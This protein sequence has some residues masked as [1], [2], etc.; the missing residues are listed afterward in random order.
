MS[1]TLHFNQLVHEHQPRAGWTARLRVRFRR[2]TLDQRLAVGAEPWS[3]TELSIRAEELTGP[4][5]RRRIAAT[6][7]RLI[8]EAEGSP[9]PMSSQVP[10]ARPAIRACTPRLRAIAGRLKSDH[11]VAPRGVAQ[12]AMLV[13]EGA[14][15]LYMVSTSET[16]LRH[17][18]A[19]V[20]EALG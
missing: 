6:I 17:R 14:S 8:A 4:Q 5:T 15:P 7:E 9:P 10:L 11:M 19:E 20:A 18:L 3:D 2:A 13:R 16:A 12:A 1:A